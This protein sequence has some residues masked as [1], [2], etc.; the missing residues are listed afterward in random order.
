MYKGWVRRYSSI[1]LGLRWGD[2]K[3]TQKL[4]SQSAHN[5]QPQQIMRVL[6][7]NAVR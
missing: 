1:I 2:G 3:I 4:V 7:T 6:A 5:A